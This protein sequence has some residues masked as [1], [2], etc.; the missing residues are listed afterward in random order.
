MQVV[1]ILVLSQY[2]NVEAVIELDIKLVVVHTY[3][4]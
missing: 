1:G 3:S 2:Y 4:C